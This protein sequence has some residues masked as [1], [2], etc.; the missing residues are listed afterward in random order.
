VPTVLLL[1]CGGA[2]PLLHPAHVLPAET[3]TLGAGVA[4]QAVGGEAREQIDRAVNAEAADVSADANSTDLRDGANASA[5]L[6][7]GLS[8]WVGA[9]VG[10]GQHSEAGVTYFGR[11]VRG[12]LRRAFEGPTYALSIG[13]GL[14]G[15]LDDPPETSTESAGGSGTE[16]EDQGTRGFGADI[17]VLVGYRS[18]ADVV[19]AWLGARVA[20]EQLAGAFRNGSDRNLYDFVGRRFAAGGVVGFMV[21]VKPVWIAVEL[22]GAYQVGRGEFEEGAEDEE[23]PRLDGGVLAGNATFTGFTYSPSGALIVRF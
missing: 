22:D 12:D 2:A 3:F 9:R 21:G 20:Y 19:Q 7:P 1:G 13:V 18:S 5:L 11:S 23:E 4:Y 14:S 17:P 6:S 15:K 10:L 16:L 8:P